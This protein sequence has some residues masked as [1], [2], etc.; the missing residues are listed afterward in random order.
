MTDREELEALRRLAELEA[1]AGGGDVSMAADVGKAAL[2]AVPKAVV[3]IAGLPMDLSRLID[4]G[5]SKLV[6]YMP[7][8]VQRGDAMRRQV[9]PDAIQTLAGMA[10]SQE[11]RKE[12]EGATGI[13]WYDPQTRIGKAADTAMQTGLLMGRNLATAPG[14]AVVGGVTAG[15]EGAG[16]LTGDDPWARAAGGLLGGGAPAALNAARSRVGAV[17]RDALNNPTP[18]Q[19]AEA[20]A[21]QDRARTV[22]IPLM[23]TEALDRGHQLAS[24]VY[25]SPSGNQTI[26]T[27]LRGRPEQ[28]RVAAQRELIDK[29]GAIGTP[30]ENA[31]RAQQTATDVIKGAEQQRSAAV[32]PYY[33]A[34]EFESIPP[35][36]MRPVAQ[37]IQ[38]QI[39]SSTV[40]SPEEKALAG[41]YKQAFPYE[42]EA[43]VP[44]A[45][46]TRSRVGPSLEIDLQKDD[47]VDAVRKLG[48]INPGDEAIGSIAKANPFPPHP[49]YGPVWRKPEHGIKSGTT[50]GHSL[51]RMA[52]LLYER[53]YVADRN[54]L[55]DVVEKLV[56]S[57]MGSG[58]YFSAWKDPAPADPLAEAINSLTKQLAAKNA[59]KISEAAPPMPEMVLPETNVG[60]L[61]RLYKNLGTEAEVPTIGATA[62][63]KIASYPAGQ[64]REALGEVLKQNN[65]NIAK[66]QRVYEQITRN[67]IEPLQAGPVG[68]LATPQGF[69]P[70][71]AANVQK[72][73]GSVSDA[74][75]VRPVD[76]K[77]L[78]QNLNAQ[79]K[80]AF[81]GI[82]QT[83]LEN[84]LDAALAD[85]RSGP[86]QTAGAKFRNAIY[87]SKQQRDNFDEMMRGVAQASGANPDDVVS[88]ARKFLE[89]LDR[90][91]RTPGLG[92]PTQPRAEIGKEMGKTLLGDTL[93]TISLTPTRPLA[94][95]FDDWIM[96]SR[97]A[98][99]ARVL[100]APDSV[101]LL[102]KMAKL[103]SSGLTARYYAAV[104]LGF[105]KATGTYQ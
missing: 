85:I 51:D 41:W 62:E 76:I 22:G 101:Q 88:G 23:G 81:P 72:V 42:P 60:R 26:E 84:S 52:E 54:A 35:Q 93:G 43:A 12:I 56:D 83:H 8:F 46:A 67:V 24:A 4:A 3:G 57:S 47:I 94:R 89:V 27:F 78:Y 63:Q 55:D 90:T 99:V 103:E 6:S 49:G 61:N 97:Y 58:R 86:L 15:T 37:A 14:L 16:A 92:S 105:G 64:V 75:S 71:D 73:V 9:A 20:V 53:G 18:G 30:A 11:F 80:R 7:E 104:L 10:G 95:R 66:G 70:K 19:I 32:S 38:K 21:L 79:D 65:P 31:A 39:F 40:G 17:V 36:S 96:R 102:A 34:A 68:R 48:G 87:G 13:P 74:N 100:T 59:P 2:S 1:K 44:V 45:A 5:R 82:V 29:T 77:T 33:K 50:A 91:G 25:A 69:D 28:V 98:D